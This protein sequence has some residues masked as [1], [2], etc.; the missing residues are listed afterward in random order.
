M[1]LRAHNLVVATY[2]S[3]KSSC[4]YISPT[5]RDPTLK[6]LPPL[7]PVAF[8]VTL[9][10][11]LL[12]S[13]S[14]S[15]YTSNSIFQLYK[16]CLPKGLPATRLICAPFSSEDSKTILLSRAIVVDNRLIPGYLIDL[17]VP[18]PV[19]YRIQCTDRIDGVKQLHP[20]KQ[21]VL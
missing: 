7:Q 17:T 5:V 18:G 19:A 1:P 9:T 10:S 6:L 20:Q 12:P 2:F 4:C 8:S 11:V 15:F 3:T 14:L 16:P 21:Q 13:P